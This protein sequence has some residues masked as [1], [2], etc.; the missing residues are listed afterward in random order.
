M[1]NIHDAGVRQEAESGGHGR[2]RALQFVRLELASPPVYLAVGAAA[3][4]F[5]FGYLQFSTTAVCCGDF[6]GYY[7]VKWSRLLW[8]GMRQGQF[9]PTFVWLPLTTLNPHDYVDHHFLFHILQIPFTWF[10]DLRTAAK[11]SAWLF[12][13]LAVFSCYWLMIRYRVRYPLLWLLALLAC[14]VD[15]Y[16]R[17]NMSKAPS[18]SIVFMVAGIYLLFERKYR[19]LAV[20]AFFYV[21]T[22]SMFVMLGVAAVIWTGVLWWSERRF[23]WRAVLWTG[24][25]V[26][27]G[28]IINPYFPDNVTLFYEHAMMKIKASDFSTKVGG[29]W[30]PYG[31]WEIL[32]NCFVAF[33]AMFIGYVAFNGADRRR[34]AR[35]L[36]F[37]LF[38]TV[39]LIIT[40]RSRR[41]VEYWP[42]FAVLFAAFAL[43]PYFES[44]RRSPD[45]LS[46][47]TAANGDDAKSSEVIAEHWSKDWYKLACVSVIAIALSTISFFSARW[48]AKDIRASD[49]PDQYRGGMEWIRRNVPRGELIFNT[50]WDDF[51]ML[52]FH[53]AD[54]RYVSGLDPTYLLDQNP[55]LARAYEDVTLGKEPNIAE[56]IRDRFGARYVFTDKKD[57]HQSFY[58]NA[59]NSGWFEEVYLDEHC[60]VLR[61]MD[62]RREQPPNAPDDGSRGGRETS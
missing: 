31:S 44:V 47:E 34:A 14:P 50:D 35:P 17:M 4:S 33:L 23:E 37:L 11:V 36:F 41:W 2:R 3:I 59:I 58:R 22:Y 49:A 13:S 21:W 42:P 25:G 7:H 10:G 9:P 48:T 53:D 32:Q 55:E 5:I 45:P 18:I 61:V 16:Y 57:V 39:L 30:Y 6:D 24:V 20:L 19:W 56:V 8:E 62:E 43:E 51:P 28:F 38:S 46:N 60:I 52:F 54:H 1:Q 12:A 40:A 15:F 27:L 26:A 29:E